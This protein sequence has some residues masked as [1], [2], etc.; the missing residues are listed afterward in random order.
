M[1]NPLYDHSAIVR[2]PR[3]ELPNGA[4]LAVWVGLNVEHYQFGTPALSL[5]PFT[6]QLVPDPLNYG[7]RDYGPRVGVWRLMEI[8]DRHRIRASAIVNAEAATRYPEIVEE[9]NKR[10]WA[11]IGHGR[12]NSTW[13][14]GM[15]PDD[16]RAYIGQVADQLEQATGARPRGWLG[17]ALTATMS[18]NDLLAEL[19]FSY[20]LDWA[21]D[22][23]PY[24]MNVANGS[25]IS[26]PYSSEVNDIPAFAIHHHT[27]AQFRDTIVDQF[28]TLYAEGADSLRIMGIG[29]HP[30][31]VGQPFRAVHFD[32]ALAHIAAREDVWLATSD[33][34]A[35]WYRAAVEH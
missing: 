3:L 19:G 30:F 26:V 4:R 32:A 33:E 34:I 18:T 11:W 20:T 29:I 5:A 12:D 15:E 22:D 8:L 24:A 28:E 23:Q 35:A 25:L 13:Q 16:E 2:R 17:P 27:G 6:A 10:G 14:T 31:L 9:G 1:E 7:W 21:N